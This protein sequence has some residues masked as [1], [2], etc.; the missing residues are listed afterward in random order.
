MS[1]WLNLSMLEKVSFNLSHR[2]KWLFLVSN[3]VFFH[4]SYR[5]KNTKKPH[6]L[7]NILMSIMTDICQRQFRFLKFSFGPTCPNPR[8]PGSSSEGIVL[9]V[10][11]SSDES[12]DGDD[13]EAECGER[14]SSVDSSSE[15]VRHHVIYID[16]AVASRPL[17]CNSTPVHEFEE[18]KQW[19]VKARQCL[20]RNAPLNSSS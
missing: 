4:F 16:P 2:D 17:W 13:D 9:P 12:D 19:L 3:S 1:F 8:C 20:K 5:H 18:I 7:F 15:S 14:E 11:T 10:D 6:E